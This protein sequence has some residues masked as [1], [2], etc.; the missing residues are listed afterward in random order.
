MI[1]DDSVKLITAKD[2]PNDASE[3]DEI[4]LPPELWRLI[5]P[6]LA[7]SKEDKKW[8]RKGATIARR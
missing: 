8:S 7:K 6:N 3:T 5:L 2:G 1:E 4:E